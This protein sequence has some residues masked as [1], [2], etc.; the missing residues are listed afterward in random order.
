MSYAVR[1]LIVCALLCLAVT[2]LFA[3]DITPI[4]PLSLSATG[5]ANVRECAQTSCAV[6]AVVAKNASLT[7]IG[8]IQGQ[9]VKKDNALWYQVTLADGRTGFA[10]SGVVKVVATPTVID[11]VS[12]P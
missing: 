1:C 2:G 11:P 7:A 6:A 3:Q 8:T 12:V 10:Y 4:S 9:A 5:K